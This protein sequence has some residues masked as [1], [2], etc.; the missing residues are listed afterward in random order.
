MAYLDQTNQDYI[1]VDI[2]DDADA[3]RVLR[4]VGYRTVPVVVPIKDTLDY[5]GLTSARTD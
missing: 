2:T 4:R 5:E 1:T 3:K